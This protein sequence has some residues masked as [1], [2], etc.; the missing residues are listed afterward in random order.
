[1]ENSGDISYTDS[2]VHLTYNSNGVRNGKLAYKYYLIHRILF[3]IRAI[4]FSILSLIVIGITV[5]LKKTPKNKEPF[6]F[7]FV[8]TLLYW[9]NTILV[10]YLDS[11]NQSHAVN[12]SWEEVCDFPILQTCLS[13]CKF[14]KLVGCERWLSL[15]FLPQFVKEYISQRLVYFWKYVNGLH[16]SVHLSK[17]LWSRTYFYNIARKLTM[18]RSVEDKVHNSTNSFCRVIALWQLFVQS[19][20]PQPSKILWWNL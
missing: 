11:W 2:A 19:L 20:S 1:M 4:F 18:R 5:Y 13:F 7:L 9:I 12:I 6:I 15:K 14:A 3:Q 10:L 16:P 8:L 17:T